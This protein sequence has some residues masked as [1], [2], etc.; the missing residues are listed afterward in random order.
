MARRI[1]D[2]EPHKINRIPLQR[3]YGPC[4]CGCGTYI[5]SNDAHM[6]YEDTYLL[7]SSCLVKY[8]KQSG[9]L[10]EIG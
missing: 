6:I 4:R 1:E 5:T 10:E 2:L 3:N 8:L 7:D 9:V